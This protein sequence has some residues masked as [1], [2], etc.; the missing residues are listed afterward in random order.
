MTVKSRMFGLPDAVIN[1][2]ISGGVH[3]DCML[4][5]GGPNTSCAECKAIVIGAI[6][7]TYSHIEKSYE[8]MAAMARDAAAD[9][10]AE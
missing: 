10:A 3:P 9:Q 4:Q 1:L 6:D 2:A 5:R 7:T 8:R